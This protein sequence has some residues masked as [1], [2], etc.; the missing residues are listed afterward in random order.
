[1]A[2][3][4]EPP[5]RSSLIVGKSLS[6]SE[7]RRWHNK[8]KS[9]R[10]LSFDF[11]C[12][13]FS[14]WLCRC[15]CVMCVCVC[16]CNPITTKCVRTRVRE[17][18]KA[19]KTETKWV[20]GK[21]KFIAIVGIADSN[22]AM[23]IYLS[24]I[25]NCLLSLAA[26]ASLSIRRQHFSNEYSVVVFSFIYSFPFNYTI[27]APWCTIETPF[28]VYAVSP[29]GWHSVHACVFAIITIWRNNWCILTLQR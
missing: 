25:Q 20:K 27:W 26:N 18:E 13:S 9:V 10:I 19:R 1:M 8:C 17:W 6:H 14:L 15:Y 12:G 4:H 16:A 28:F 11:L 23:G 24:I 2:L 29:F 5:N 21:N 7:H 22:I 3:M